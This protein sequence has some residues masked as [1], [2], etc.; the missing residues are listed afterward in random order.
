MVATVPQSSETMVE[1]RQNRLVTPLESQ[2]T[3]RLPVLLCRCAH[4]SPL[5]QTGVTPWSSQKSPRGAKKR[6]N[7]QGWA[8]L[9]EACP[10][11]GI[12]D[13]ALH[14]LVSDGKRGKDRDIQYLKC[15]CCQKR[16]SSRKGSGLYYLKTS[17]DRVE[18]VLWF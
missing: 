1:T 7:T 14:A 15:Q 2:V 3:R 9:N 18:M 11:F 12:R 8:C 4:S 16:F 17:V 5:H 6:L 13:A 10:Y